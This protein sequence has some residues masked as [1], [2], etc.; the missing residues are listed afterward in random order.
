MGGVGDRA[1][2]DFEGCWRREVRLDC[3]RGKR[4]FEGKSFLFLCAVD[5]HLPT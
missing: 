4:D 2:G 1:A 5:I 3:G